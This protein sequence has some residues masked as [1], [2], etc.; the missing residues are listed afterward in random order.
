MKNMFRIAAVAGLCLAASILSIRAQAQTHGSG[1]P[2][3]AYLSRQNLNDGGIPTSSS[4]GWNL[5]G[6]GSLRVAVCSDAGTLQGAGTIQAEL[7]SIAQ[8][9]WMHVPDWDKSVTN[10]G[11]GCQSW[12]EFTVLTHSGQVK[13]I[14]EGVTARLADAGVVTSGVVSIESVNN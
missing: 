1:Y 14:A 8:A 11:E 7:Y 12:N 9:R 2:V 4:D 3:T 5:Y 6:T 10:I 13:F